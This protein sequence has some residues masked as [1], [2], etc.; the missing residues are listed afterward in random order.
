VSDPAPARSRVLGPI[1]AIYWL[2]IFAATHLPQT[3]LPQPPMG[4]KTEH[5]I[6]YAGLSVLL[7]TWLIFTRPK[8]RYV[9]VVAILVC[10]LYGAADEITQP[11]V[12]RFCDFRDFLADCVGAGL[13]ILLTM[14]VFRKRVQAS[15]GARV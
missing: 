14:I 12:N 4:D 7:M 15:A 1:L 11:I 13:G 2:G 10:A 5:F 8:V 6:A 3:A 9:W